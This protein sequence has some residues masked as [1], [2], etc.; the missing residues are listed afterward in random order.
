[1]PTDRDCKTCYRDMKPWGPAF[2]CHYICQ[3][4]GLFYWKGAAALASGPG[5]VPGPM[6]IVEYVPGDIRDKGPEVWMG[7]FGGMDVRLSVNDGENLRKFGINCKGGRY[8]LDPMVMNG[9]IKPTCEAAG[10]V[11]IAAADF[12]SPRTDLN[13]HYEG[14]IVEK[15]V[16]PLRRGSPLVIPKADCKGTLWIMLTTIK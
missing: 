6:P 13:Y 4:F 5:P 11:T 12:V 1:M 15:S 2:V 8:A 7:S 14:C 9:A 3:R 16:Y 10:N